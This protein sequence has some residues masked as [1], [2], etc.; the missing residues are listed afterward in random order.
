MVLSEPL[1]LS[2]PVLLALVLEAR[3]GHITQGEVSEIYAGLR[4]MALQPCTRGRGHGCY[5][6]L[7]SILR[8]IQ[9]YVPEICVISA[10]G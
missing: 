9:I 6:D 10:S 2:S 5:K 3:D 8:Q 4:F 7:F 1:V